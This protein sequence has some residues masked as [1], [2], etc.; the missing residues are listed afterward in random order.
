MLTLFV[1]KGS[2]A[3]AS[4]VAIAESGLAHDIAWVDFAANAQQSPEYLAIN[5]KGRVPALACDQGVLTETPAIL[6]HLARLTPHLL[7]TDPWA[8]ARA[9]EWLSYLASTMHIAHAHNK[10][11]HRWSDDAAAIKAMTA[12]VPVTMAASCAHVESLL[13]QT[14]LAL[15]AF[16]IVDCHLYAIARWLGG[17]G[18]DIDAYPRLSA[19]FTA[20]Q[21]RPCVQE[22]EALHG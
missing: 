7:P 16:S 18:V 15:G 4:H 21:A 20:M 2:I 13:P 9:D 17:D 6:R 14:G 22:I 8:E 19:H 12:H 1:A 5:P 3:L 10:R 11:G